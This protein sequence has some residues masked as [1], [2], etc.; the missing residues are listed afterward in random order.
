MAIN[1]NKRVF[2]N[3]AF[4]QGPHG[5]PNTFKAKGKGYFNKLPRFPATEQNANAVLHNRATANANEEHK[6]YLFVDYVSTGWK[7]AGETTQ[8]HDSRSFYP[9]NLIQNDVEIRGTVANNYEYDRLVRFVEHHQNSVLSA[10]TFRGNYF[11]A[12]E[13]LL[14]KPANSSSFYHTSTGASGGKMFYTI[15]ILGIEAGA[16]RFKNAPTFT[17]RC[18]VLHD[19]LRGKSELDQAIDRK[20]NY[21]E[22][23]GGPK[24]ALNTARYTAKTAPSKDTA[25]RVSANE[26]ESRGRYAEK[27]SGVARHPGK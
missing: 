18:K 2:G 14:F 15:A 8:T 16:E 4:T 13:F 9:R 5:Q 10:E 11:P 6:I 25:V 7:V 1:T 21:K 23:F 24:V 27:P 20:I 19:H 26:R 12:V 22:I 3:L 17:L